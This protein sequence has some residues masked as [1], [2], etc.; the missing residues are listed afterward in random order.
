MNFYHVITPTAKVEE[1]NEMGSILS[2]FFSPEKEIFFRVQVKRNTEEVF[3][4][5]AWNAAIPSF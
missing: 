1:F 2:E 5:I 4:F 3:D